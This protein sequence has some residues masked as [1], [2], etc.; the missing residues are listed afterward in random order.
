MTKPNDLAEGIAGF[1][2]AVGKAALGGAV[3]EGTGRV[4]STLRS[5]DDKLEMVRKLAQA[6]MHPCARCGKPRVEHNR[7][8][9]PGFIAIHVEAKKVGG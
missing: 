8:T 1:L 5:I 3:R 7:G 6:S 9:C 2:S 4:Q